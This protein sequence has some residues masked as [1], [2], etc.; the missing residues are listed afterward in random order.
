MLMLEAL[1]T[2]VFDNLRL[3][4]ILESEHPKSTNRTDTMH[5]MHAVLLLLTPA[6]VAAMVATPIRPLKAGTESRSWPAFCDKAMAAVRAHP[7]VVGTEYCAWWS[8]GA[9][10]E[11]QQ[12]DLVRARRPGFRARASARA[13]TSISN[14][15]AARRVTMSRP[16]DRVTRGPP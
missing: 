2:F 14:A 1:L 16:C 15:A 12:Q 7:V 4:A 5:A 6:M 3:G 13:S 9:A 8:T 10:N 11:K